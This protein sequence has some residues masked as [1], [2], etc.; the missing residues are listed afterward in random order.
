VCHFIIISLDRSF[1]ASTL[2]VPK[3]EKIELDSSTLN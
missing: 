2:G 3:R 1:I